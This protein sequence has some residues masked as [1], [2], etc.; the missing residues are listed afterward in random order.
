MGG[1][2]LVKKFRYDLDLDIGRLWFLSIHNIVYM[3]E[4]I[5]I[6]PNFI[7]FILR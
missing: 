3:R 4:E 2:L 1:I 7:D 5:C 6:L